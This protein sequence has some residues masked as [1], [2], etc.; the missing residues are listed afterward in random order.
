M[1]PC[2]VQGAPYDGTAL[3][4]FFMAAKARVVIGR[5]IDLTPYYGYEEDAIH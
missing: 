3:G 1:I 2:F 5:P 4:S